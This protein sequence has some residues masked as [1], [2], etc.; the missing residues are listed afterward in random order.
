MNLKG[1]WLSFVFSL[2][3]T[4]GFAQKRENIRFEN[5]TIQQGLS[6]S[7]VFD[8][9]Q[10]RLGYLWVGTMDGVDRYDG[11]SFKKYTHFL[12]DSTTLAKGWVMSLTEKKNGDIVLGTS[13]GNISILNKK[14]GKFQNFQNWK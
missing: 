12:D 8:I 13:L 1:L 11:Y 14:T 2:F 5:L 10:D 3:F 9:H 6:Q 4:P 7:S